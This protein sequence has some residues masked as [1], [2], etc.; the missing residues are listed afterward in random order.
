MSNLEILSFLHLS[1]FCRSDF[2]GKDLDI[3][4]IQFTSIDRNLKSLNVLFVRRGPTR[5]KLW[6]KNVF[7]FF[8]IWGTWYKYVGQFFIYLFLVFN[9]VDNEIV[10]HSTIYNVNVFTLTRVGN[11]MAEKVRKLFC[12]NIYLPQIK[13]G[14][15]VVEICIYP[16]SNNYF[17]NSN[18]YVAFFP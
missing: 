9:V 4:R 12:G 7:F 1:L 14:N 13:L 16:K 18:Q 6:Y 10:G 17:S 5:D 3:Y 15:F 11:H 8:F 2:M